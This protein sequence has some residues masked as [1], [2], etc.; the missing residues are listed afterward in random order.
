MVN[1]LKTTRLTSQKKTILAILRHFKPI[2]PTS[3]MVYQRVRK[4]LPHISL[5]T[6]YRNLNYLKEAGFAEEIPF[7]EEPSRYDG[8]VDAHLHF[9]CESC[10]DLFDINDPKY[11]E[12]TKRH[13]ER[14]GFQVQRFNIIYSGLCKKCRSTKEIKKT[15]CIVCS[16]YG[17]VKT[18][19][20]K[21][22]KCQICH[23]QG[24][25][26]YHTI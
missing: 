18:V 5:G 2:H 11:L 7:G 24:E 21:N 9:R 26:S 3:Y 16:A 15:S 1:N 17:K 6:V 4:K 12:A 8:R 10:K 25:C 19:L 22:D 14:K 23:F 13:L 20:S